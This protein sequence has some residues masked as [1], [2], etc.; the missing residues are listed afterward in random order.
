MKNEFVVS[1][2]HVHSEQT[3][4]ERKAADEAIEEGSPD[5]PI[6]VQVFGE[7]F[8]LPA[9]TVATYFCRPASTVPFMQF[10]L[11]R[12]PRRSRARADLPRPGQR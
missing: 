8:D 5:V 6:N 7:G 3:T 4:A 9:L 1:T 2:M 12:Q 10:E 11:V